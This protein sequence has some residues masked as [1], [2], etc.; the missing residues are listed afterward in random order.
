[1][2][3][4][5]IL[6]LVFFPYY[7]C[8]D[9]LGPDEDP[10]KILGV[11]RSASQADIKRAYKK[12][13]RNWHPDKNNDPSAQEMFIKINEAN[14]ILSDEEKKRNFDMF[15]TTSQPGNGGPQGK[16]FYDP[17]SG[18]SFFFN[19]MPFQNSWS[20][21]G[22]INDRF[23]YKTVLPE[24]YEK[25]YLI[26]IISDW[27]FACA[28]IEEIWEEASNK[29]K[30]VGVGIGIINVHRSLRLAD[31]L[32]AG[33]VPSIIGVING[34]V[35]FYNEIVTVQGLKDFVLELF[36]R[37]LIEKVTASS[38]DSFL[39]TSISNKPSVILFSP[40]PNPSLLYHLVAFRNCKQ[41][42]FGFVSLTDSSSEPLR[43]RFR[44]N[45]KEPTV[46]IFK[47]DVAV[48]DVVVMASELKHG[49]LREVVESHKYL[50]LPRL[51]SR[52]LFDELCPEERFRSQRRL[53]VV[54]FTKQGQ[55]DKEKLALRLFATDKKYLS[56]RRLKF[57]Y[58]YEDVQRDLVEEFKDGVKAD[59][60][61]ENKT[62]SKVIVLWNKGQKQVRYD[63]LPGGWCVNESEEPLTKARLSVMLEDLLSGEGKLRYTSSIPRIYN[64]HAPGLLS[65]LF[66][67]CSD[68]Y[69]FVKSS[70]YRR[71]TI[72]L[73]SLLCGLGVILVFS[74]FIPSANEPINRVYKGS[75]RKNQRPPES[76]SVLGL[77]RLDHSTEKTLI[78][79]A[80]RGQITFTLLVDATTAREVVKLPLI[81]AFADVIYPHSGNPNFRFTWLSITDNLAWCAEIL[82]VDKFGEVTP[83]IV[84]ALNGY[85]KYLSVFKPSDLSEGAFFKR[86]GGDLMGFDDSDSDTDA[87]EDGM[88]EYERKRQKVLSRSI[89]TQLVH[90]LERFCDGMVDRKRVVEW[91]RFTD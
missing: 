10:Y 64:E 83:G 52:S 38:L 48:P 27:C 19:G 63:W 23:Y 49:K 81:Q 87:N 74:V 62:A 73:F 61:A 78:R 37:G 84:L 56:E 85:K 15:G 42:S 22:E 50:H 3:N 51:S 11:T 58:I 31:A 72:S 66:S 60:C 59:S 90:W 41:Q 29:I 88:T 9:A 33:R 16:P 18:F 76:E 53:C 91:P 6:L 12:M 54:L 32:G 69:Y 67:W 44:V 71:E 55:N 17:H 4:Y 25:P 39:T 34:R 68:A 2:R 7:L 86:Q 80:P 82:D 5:L 79:D 36:P 43:K 77:L 40:K 65:L 30:R 28:Q 24:S 1:M 46:L 26:E 35:A 13:A 47:D 89:R 45:S 57:L 8:L 21:P 70:L 75:S 20:K 14:E